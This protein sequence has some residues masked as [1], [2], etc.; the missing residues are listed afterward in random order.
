MIAL[1]TSALFGATGVGRHER[2]REELAQ[3][4]SLNA[5]LSQENQRLTAEAKALRHNE[6]FIESVIRDELG[7]VR[8][9]E[10]VFLFSKTRKEAR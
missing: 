9:D 10:L 2:L 3:V 5:S 4:E 8:E 1:V 7:W 6:R